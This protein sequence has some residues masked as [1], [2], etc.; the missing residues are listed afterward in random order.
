MGEEAKGFAVV[1][2]HVIDS[3]IEMDENGKTEMPN[4]FVGPQNLIK[5]KLR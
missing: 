3:L 1:V 5:S 4:T 2:N